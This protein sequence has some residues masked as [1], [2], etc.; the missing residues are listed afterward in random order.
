MNRGPKDHTLEG[1]VQ[2]PTTTP[3]PAQD[4]V[5]WKGESDCSSLI[6]PLTSVPVAHKV[7]IKKE[8]K[9]RI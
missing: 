8:L 6:A 4:E 9:T 3:S 7:K 5:T 2:S 1:Q